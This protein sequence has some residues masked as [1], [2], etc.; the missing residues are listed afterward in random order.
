LPDRPHFLPVLTSRQS[1][2][3]HFVNPPSD[4]LIMRIH[5]HAFYMYEQ[6]KHL[7]TLMD[8]P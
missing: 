8:T 1:S 3:N 6:A 5:H 7:H 4:L 2:L